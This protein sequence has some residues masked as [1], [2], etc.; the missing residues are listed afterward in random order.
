MMNES[1]RLE[2]LAFTAL[3]LTLVA[4]MLFV[5]L[6]PLEVGLSG[7]PG[8]DL[9]LCLTLAWVLRR[10]LHV[11]VLVIALVFLVEDLLLMRPP[12]LWALI[13]LGATAF[14][15]RRRPAVREV[16]LLV[17]WGVVAAVMAAM[18]LVQRVVLVIVMVP[19]P[20]L[21]LSLLKLVV[22]VLVY[23]LVVGVLQGVFRVRKPATGEV[24]ERGRKL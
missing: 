1:L 5:R 17:E 12:G 15:R 4:G 13:V 2:T 9:V 18:V 16:G 23:P 24:D 6:L 10:P 7:L 19:L 14:L 21:D 11:P 3:Y 8:P 20:P 22:T